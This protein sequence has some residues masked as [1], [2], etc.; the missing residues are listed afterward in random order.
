MATVFSR[1]YAEAIV[2]SERAIQHAKDLRA[3][4]AAHLA[5]RIKDAQDALVDD[6]IKAAPTKITEAAATGARAADLLTFNGADTYQDLNLVFLVRG[7]R[8]GADTAAPGAAS[9][10][11]R[12]RHLMEP[13]VVRHEW[14]AA[15]G[16]NRVVVS[17]RE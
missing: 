15:T 8:R 9:I 12:L 5:Q 2:E 14:D 10:L 4:E 1:L 16:G 6:I 3:E 13:F 11:P 17:W 7:P